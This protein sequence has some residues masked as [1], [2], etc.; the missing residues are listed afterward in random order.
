M[1]KIKDLDI[2]FGDNSSVVFDTSFDVVENKTTCIIGETGSGKSVILL[3]ILGLL[4]D[5]VSSSSTI[6]L[7]E[8][9]L[10]ALSEKELHIIR[11][12][13]LSY[14]PQGSGNGLNPLYK[15]EHQII[16]TL[17]L[18]QKISK[19]KAKL[20]CEELLNELGFDDAKK[21]LKSYPHQ[22]SGGMRQRVLISIGMAS[23]AHTLL[24][25]EP[26]KGLD[27]FRISLVVDTF[28]RIKNRTILCV[29][30]D[31]NF[32]KIIGNY[33]I[34]MYASEMIESC[35]ADQFFSNP[36][37]P[38][39]QNMLSALPENGLVTDVGFAPPR[40]DMDKQRACKFI[41]RCNCKTDKCKVNPPLLQ[42]GGNRKVRCWN[43]AT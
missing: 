8:K 16:E 7:D 2:S 10:L 43:Y 28:E 31:L 36:L 3:A 41:E 35:D 30:H 6:L 1:L 25:D 32:A 40:E 9:N 42:I 33:V 22:L 26:T 4:P 24:V 21:V 18:T 12:Y 19:N 23:E 39:S 38:Y 34:V 15:I 11:K 20:R 27:K 14:I 13:H 5:A 37:H 29:T 17:Q